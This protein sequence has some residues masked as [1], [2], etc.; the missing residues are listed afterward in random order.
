MPKKREPREL[1]VDLRGRLIETV[2]DFVEAI[3]GPCGLPDFVG[4][5]GHALG[6]VFHNGGLSEVVDSYDRLVFHVDKRGLF[7]R[8]DIDAREFRTAFAGSRTKL[9]THPPVD[10]SSAVTPG[11]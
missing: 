5:S 11:S 9:V 4:R 10:R 2:D 3:T 6:D 1:V 7:A 8:R